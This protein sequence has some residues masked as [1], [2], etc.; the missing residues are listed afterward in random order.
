MLIH[1]IFVWV[2]V[3]RI[4]KIDKVQRATANAAVHIS[5]IHSHVVAYVTGWIY[6]GYDKVRPEDGGPLILD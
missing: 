2:W 3:V 5:T 6:L 4:A 1:F